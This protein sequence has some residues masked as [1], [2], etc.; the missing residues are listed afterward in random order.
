MYPHY[1]PD[2]E[3]P[4]HWW[5]R[6]MEDPVYV[7]RFV[8]RWREMRRG[9]FNTDSVMHF[10]DS[11]TNY[12][13]DEITKNFQKWPILGT[14]VW[15]NYYVGTTYEDDLNFLKSWLT[16]RLNW[17]DLA[18]GLNSGLYNQSFSDDGIVIYPIPVKD[19]LTIAINVVT[20]GDLSFEF[21]DLFGRKIYE[22]VFK[23]ASEGNQEIFIDMSQFN[24]GYYILKITQGSKQLATKKVVKY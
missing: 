21:I 23:P 19:K 11:T 18:T 4:M 5:A 14:W 16:D 8:T 13:G 9:A 20:T 12:L 22:Y 24:T 6:L 17:M 3:H 2:W 15:P 10:I 7:R 1:A